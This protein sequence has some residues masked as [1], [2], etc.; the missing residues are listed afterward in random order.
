[1]II[2]AFSPNTSHLMPRI[3]CRHLRHCAPIM[4]IAP[5][6]YIMY[7]FVR[8]GHIATIYLS[9]RAI[10]ILHAH[11]WKFICV[12]GRALPR[13]MLRCARKCRTCVALCKTAIRYNAP[14]VITPSGLFKKMR[15]D[16]AHFFNNSLLYIHN[17]VITHGACI[18]IANLHNSTHERQH[19]RAR[20]IKSYGGMPGIDI[21]RHPCIPNN[22]IKF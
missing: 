3:F 6:R 20:R 12:Q 4:C 15:A 21:N 13:D 17:G 19:I 10:Q 2:I 5:N 1:M 22:F 9:L 7:Q 18:S 14:C 8:R 16:G 11:G